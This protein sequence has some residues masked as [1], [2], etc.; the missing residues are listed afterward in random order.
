MTKI[1]EIVLMLPKSAS[2]SSD[3]NKDLTFKAK[4]KDKD[5]TL[6]AKDQD[7]D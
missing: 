5:K 6:K 7:K 2:K 3:V 4:A 1:A